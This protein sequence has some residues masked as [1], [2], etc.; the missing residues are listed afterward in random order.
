MGIDELINALGELCKIQHTTLATAES[1][2][3]GG[4]AFHIS[5]NP[6]C[7]HL[8]E[9]GYIAY[10]MDAKQELGVQAASLQLQGAVSEVVAIEMAEA[11]LKKTKAQVCIATTGIDEK[12]ASTDVHNQ[13]GL[14]WIAC[15]GMDR[16]TVTKQIKVPGNREEFATQTLI[17]SLEVLLDFLK[18]PVKSH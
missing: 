8:L 13:P 5:K 9:R 15:A 11:T 18:S 6:S 14:V 12:T 10:S 2:T 4:L 16:K 1:C 3:G 7:S 17:A